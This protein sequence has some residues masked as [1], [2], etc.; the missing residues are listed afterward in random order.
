MRR[1]PVSYVIAW[2]SGPRGSYSYFGLTMISIERT[3]R[4]AYLPKRVLLVGE[5]LHVGK[6]FVDERVNDDQRRCRTRNAN[7][8]RH[9]SAVV[10]LNNFFFS[11]KRIPIVVNSR[12]LMLCI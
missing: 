6:K 11:E 5:H 9:D 10:V 12:F 8:L 7:A 4:R 3:V 1:L 2:T